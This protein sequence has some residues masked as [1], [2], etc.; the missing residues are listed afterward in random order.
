M[1]NMEMSDVERPGHMHMGG[2]EMADMEEEMGDME[3]KMGD[4]EEEMTD[5][6]ESVS[7]GVYRPA[8]MQPAAR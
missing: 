7:P 3:E 2:M 4:L 8:M 5:H 6:E 1:A